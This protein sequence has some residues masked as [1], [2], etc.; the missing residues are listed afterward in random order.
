MPQN[1]SGEPSG[2]GVR[3]ALVVAR[4]NEAIT[5][6]LLAGAEAYL[7]R[8]GCTAERRLVAW[9]PGSWELPQGASR[10]AATGDVDAVIALGAL[11][12]GETAHFDYIAQ[13]VS[14]GLTRVGLDSGIP[15]AFGVLTTDDVEQA[16]AR[17]G[18]GEDDEDNKGRDAARAALEMA[19]L[20]RRLGA[21]SE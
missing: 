18:P 12:R 2:A 9:V 17:S 7:E 14:Q 15:V 6:R 19:D 10:V 4:F 16:L 20:F 5:S 11:I 8:Q 21:G 13:A 1:V 3:V